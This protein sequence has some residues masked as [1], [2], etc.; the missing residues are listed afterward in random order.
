[1]TEQTEQT[2]WRSGGVVVTEYDLVRNY[3]HVSA[4]RYGYTISKTLCPDPQALAKFID[5][6]Q[7]KPR[8][9]SGRDDDSGT[10]SLVRDGMKPVVLVSNSSDDLDARDI[11]EHLA[12]WLNAREADREA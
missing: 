9:V 2:E 4:A 1:M 7:P 5:S 8:Y 6:Q 11:A 3:W 12:D 10:L